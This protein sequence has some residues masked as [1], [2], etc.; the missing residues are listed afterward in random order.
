MKMDDAYTKKITIA[1]VLVILLVLSFFLL[2]PILLAIITGIILAFIF[3]P[4]YKRLYK[5]VKSKNLSAIIICALLLGVIILPFYFLIPIFVDQSIGFYSSSQQIDFTTTIKNIFPSVIS[6]DKF[7]EE[8]GSMIRNLVTTITNSVIAYL[9]KLIL[10][11]PNL[12]LQL[13]VVL[14]TFY[15]ALMEKDQFFSYARSLIP[16]PKD[17][18][19]KLIDQTRLVTA[20]VIYGQVIIGIIQGAVAEIGRAHV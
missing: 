11:I 10:N 9:S 7:S 2:K 12:L 1:I 8:I 3:A 15:F 20:S 18:E 17:V 4:V 19:K 6:S 5:L 14:F 16:F 13:V